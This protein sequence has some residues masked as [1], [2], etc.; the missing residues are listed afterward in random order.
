M[1]ESVKPHPL[2]ESL[3]LVVE[4]SQELTDAYHRLFDEARRLRAKSRSQTQVASDPAQQVAS[5]P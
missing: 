1:T 3:R 2:D 4:S 5:Q